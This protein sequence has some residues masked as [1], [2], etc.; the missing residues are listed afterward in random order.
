MIEDKMSKPKSFK[1]L[2]G[3]RFHRLLVISQAPSDKN[4][5]AKWHCNCDCG[6]KTISHGFSL[7]NGAAKSCG[8]LT[9][10]QA[11]ERNRRHDN[12]GTSEYLSWAAMIQRCEN[13]KNIRY[14]RYGERGITVCERW[15]DFV[16]FLEDMGKK[17]TEKYTI[18]RID[19][20]G[21]YE[22]NNCRW[23]TKAEQRHNQSNTHFVIYR[24]ARMSLT[25][26]IQRSGSLINIATA[27]GRLRRGWSVEDAINTPPNPNIFLPKLGR[28]GHE[29]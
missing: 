7:R 28:Y 19:N 26:A 20:D 27:L 15:H 12:H 2:T 29:K 24:G 5:N 25:L 10:Q 6:N 17:P 1:D 9:G 14:N 3:Q 13:P 21:N 18:E 8:C 16:H 11:A 22:P 23:A 4:G